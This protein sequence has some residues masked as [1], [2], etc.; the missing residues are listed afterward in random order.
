MTFLSS[1][2]FILL[3]II[4]R[5]CRTTKWNDPSVYDYWYGI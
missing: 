3:F 2:Y 4:G 5:R 1:V